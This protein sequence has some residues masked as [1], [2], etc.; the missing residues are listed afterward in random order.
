MVKPET[1]A[2]EMKRHL[3]ADTYHAHAAAP[4]I[5]FIQQVV[6]D[7]EQYGTIVE[8]PVKQV[9]EFPVSTFSIDVETGAYANMRRMLNL[10]RSPGEFGAITLYLETSE[11]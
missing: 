1:T 8:N 5:S 10:G 3:M 11:G 6:P 9:A 2:L 7:R 4:A